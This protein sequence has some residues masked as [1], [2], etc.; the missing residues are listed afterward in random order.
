MEYEKIYFS[1]VR[2][3]K[4]NKFDGYT[5]KHHILPRSLGGSDEN[6]NLVNLSAREHYIC[7]LLLTKMYKKHSFEYNKMLHAFMMMCNVNSSNQERNYKVNSKLYEKYKLEFKSLM[8]KR[9]SGEKNITYGT[10]WIHSLDERR[11]KR[12]TESLS[13]PRGWKDDS[14]ILL[15]S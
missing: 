12:I 14:V 10:R 7:H 6:S 1:I 11:S 5:E 3:R 4:I 2:N 8:S 9:Q 13:T 15:V